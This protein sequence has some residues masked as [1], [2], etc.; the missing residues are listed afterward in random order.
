MRWTR[1]D[2]YGD[3]DRRALAAQF[4]TAAPFPHVVLDDVLAPPP[5]DVVP[6]FPGPDWPEW[7]GFKDRYQ[8]GKLFCQDPDLLPE[9]F[10]ALIQE[11][12][13]A[14]FLSFLEEVTGI[15]RLLPDPHLEGGGLHCTGPG[16][17][18]TPHTDFHVYRRL[19]LYRQVN[20]LLYFN[21]DWEPGNGG[22]LELWAKGADAPTVRVGPVYGRCVIFRTDDRSVHGFSTVGPGFWRR[23]LALYYYTALESP[24]FSGDTTTY[25]QEHGRHAGVGKVRLALYHGLLFVSRGFA[26]A[27]HRANPSIGFKNRPP[28]PKRRQR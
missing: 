18:L 20:L 10:V 5:S 23:S 26:F 28:K 8:A 17:Q 11:L 1:F 24:R 6:L 14:R 4:A 27:A 2:D 3:A 7:T 21:D 12:S 13:S 9:Q 19:A 22:E 15:P 25:W 16:G